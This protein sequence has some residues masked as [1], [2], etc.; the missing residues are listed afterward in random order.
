MVP[1]AQQDAVVGVGWP[2]SGVFCVVVDLAPARWHCAARDDASTVSQGDRLALVLVEDAVGDT[3]LQN[4]AGVGVNH[5][6]DAPAT[7]GV[8]GNADAGWFV[9]A[10]DDREPSAGRE[11]FGAHRDDECWGGTADGGEFAC[12]GGDG[13]R[14]GEGVVLLLGLAAFVGPTLIF[15]RIALRV[16]QKPWPRALG[17]E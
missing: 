11:V 16:A 12:T 9:G 6:L 8:P 2:T 14:R 3:E 4:S 13:E 7:H 10:V 15:G 1:P 5:S 17:S